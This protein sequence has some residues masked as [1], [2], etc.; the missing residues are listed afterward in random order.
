L[1]VPVICGSPQDLPRKPPAVL[2]GTVN[3]VVVVSDKT[4]LKYNLAVRV[5]P[6]EDTVITTC[7]SVS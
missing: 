1:K 7:T 3:A 6:D 2:S 5:P 4:P